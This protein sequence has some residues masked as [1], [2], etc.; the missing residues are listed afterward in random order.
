V[1]TNSGFVGS[2]NAKFG[3]LKRHPAFHDIPCRDVALTGRNYESPHRDG[4]GKVVS[5]GAFLPFGTPSSPGQV[6]RSQ[7]PCGGAIMRVPLAGGTPEL[8]AWGFPNPFGLAFAPDGQLYVSDNSYDDRGCRP[9]WG[10]ADVLWRVTPGA[11]YGWPDYA[12]GFPL[13]RPDFKPP[14]KPPVD[15]LLQQAPGM[16]HDPSR[17]FPCTRLRQR[18]TA[19]AMSR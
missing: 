12:E 8:V 5:I 6:I 1:A 18:Y 7:V 15:I 3:W 16:R 9:V 19:C 11:W 17:A 13:T 4:S 14:G 2:D 10:S